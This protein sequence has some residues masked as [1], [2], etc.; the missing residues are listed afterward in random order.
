MIAVALLAFLVR[1]TDRS[2]THVS[3]RHA[4][5]RADGRMYVINTYSR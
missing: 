3:E 4:G 2:L 5:T 1:F